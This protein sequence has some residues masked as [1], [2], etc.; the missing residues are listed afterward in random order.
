M[1]SAG[2]DNLVGSVHQISYSFMVLPRHCIKTSSIWSLWQ[3][4]LL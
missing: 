2:D 3:A 1:Y 4:C